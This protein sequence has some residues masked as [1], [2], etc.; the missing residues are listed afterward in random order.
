MRDLLSASGRVMNFTAPIR[1]KE[2]G[3][4]LGDWTNRVSW[5]DVVE[6]ITKEELTKIRSERVPVTFAYLL[7]QDGDF[8]NA[9][10]RYRIRAQREV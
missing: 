3:E 2:T 6:A 5:S 7:S 1:S 4:I 9:P 8:P 10:Q